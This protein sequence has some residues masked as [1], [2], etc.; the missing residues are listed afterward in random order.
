MADLLSYLIDYYV[1][2]LHG[3]RVVAFEKEIKKLEQKQ[4]PIAQ[5]KLDDF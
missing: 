1:K 5:K 3:E 4:K 2:I